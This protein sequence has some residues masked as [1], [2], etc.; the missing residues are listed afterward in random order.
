M[1][2]YAANP[3][4]AADNPVKLR[5]P[6][7]LLTLISNPSGPSPNSFTN[8]LYSIGLAQD[9]YDRYTFYRLLSQMG[10]SSAPEP[11]TYPV[12]GAS[13]PIITQILPLPIPTKGITQG[14]RNQM[15]YGTVPEPY[16]YVHGR[17]MNLNY[18]NVGRN[19]VALTAT[20]FVAWQAVEFFTNAADRLLRAYY[21]NNI[22]VVLTINGVTRPVVTNININFIP[23]YPVNYYTPGVHRL[24]Q[25][26]ANMYDATTNKTGVV[27]FDYPSV[28]RP[29]F[30]NSSSA[31]GTTNLIYVA[32][33]REMLAPINNDP[34]GFWNKPLD[35]RRINDYKT[36]ISDSA[37]GIYPDPTNS[38]DNVYGVP[39]VI[40]ARTNLPNF[41][42]FS[43]AP[44]VQITR[45]M[46]L[47][48]TGT[49]LQTNISYVIGVSNVM[50]V[51][52]WNSGT[53]FLQGRTVNIWF[54]NEFS[55]LITNNFGAPP[56]Y[57]PASGIPQTVGGS[58]N[59]FNW[60]PG[61]YRGVQVPVAFQPFFSNLVTMQNTN[62]QLSPG[63]YTFGPVWNPVTR[64]PAT[65]TYFMPD[66]GLIITNNLRVVMTDVGSGRIL[67]CVQLGGLGQIVGLDSQDDVTNNLYVLNY[68]NT[69]YNIY[70]PTPTQ[71]AAAMSQPVGFF[72]QMRIS[73]ILSNGQPLVPPQ[74]WASAPSGQPS[75]NSVT[76]AIS[77]FDIWLA[78]TQQGTKQVPF[79]P[80]VSYAKVYTWCANDPLV[81]Y[82]VGDVTDL[83]QSATN[84]P[85]LLTMSAPTNVLYKPLTAI[86]ARYRPWGNNK[87]LPAQMSLVPSDE[88]EFKDPL[89]TQSQ[90]FQFPGNRYPNVGW[91]GRVHRGTPWQTVYLKSHG[92]GFANT[93]SGN[94][95]YW[96]G[97]PD[98]VDAANTQPIND[99]AL[100]D[101]FTTSPN[102]NAS[103]GQLSVNQ[104][105]LAAWA[106]VLDGVMVISNAPTGLFATNISIAQTSVVGTTLTNTVQ[107]MVSSINAQ[108]AT[109]GG[110][111]FTSIGQ[112]FSTPQLTV[113]SPY[114]NTGAANIT[115]AEYERIPQQIGSLLRV[116]TPRYE[117]YAYGQSLKP[118]DK[119]I[120]QS[121]PFFGMCT[122]YQITGEVLTRTVVRF[123][124]MPVPGALPPGS[125]VIYALPIQGL[126]SYA[127]V[128]N[129]VPPMRAV[130]ESF[131][132][133]GPDQ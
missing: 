51:Q 85:E 24:L 1:A 92:P 4:S 119:S 23:I 90:D 74:Y 17:K 12:G 38:F 120:V 131:E 117:I 114:L 80:T 76:N 69:N 87:G 13:T 50:G 11:A 9:T 54:T 102:D 99:W 14:G 97:N 66:W 68:P 21:P 59:I 113:A 109:V 128:T 112:L 126:N 26:A 31:G 115:D 15:A 72:N 75:L 57:Y 70:D 133:L 83:T 30:G 122:N 36:L 106:A 6:R 73:M 124:N 5:R 60:P 91:I 121:G 78:G 53:N 116:G 98:P 46:Q 77:G 65:K 67:D 18:N 63:A 86:S 3:W 79:A 10:F 61:F 96:T 49:T 105:S 19:G 25:L 39:C 40:G 43:M 58:T 47:V 33:Y 55:M 110:G 2:T 104:T 100:L 125:A 129:L 28:F 127:V 71:P 118:A 32:G 22:A 123:D 29:F 111:V 56:S 45:A 107:Y 84:R 8:R 16:P 103:R 95:Q 93:F 88:L 42:Q 7:D 101:L 48:R 62:V 132:I 94:W 130:V 37:R 27:Q 82:M 20:N 64:N 52:C 41:N 44:V 108:R 81:H 89:I 34:S 35:F